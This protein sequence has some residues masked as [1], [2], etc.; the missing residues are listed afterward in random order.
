MNKLLVV[1]KSKDMIYDLI[2]L[3]DGFILSPREL[4]VN[5]PYFFF[6]DDILEIARRLKEKNKKVF[7]NINKN[8]NDDDLRRLKILLLKLSQ[9]AV[10]LIDG[11][12]YYD[13]SLVQLKIKYDLPFELIWAQEHMTNNYL[14]CNFW[15]SSGVN[16]V[17]L[18]NELMLEEILEIR[19]HTDMN[20][21]YQ[22][23]GYIP[24]FT[25]KRTLLTSYIDYCDLYRYSDRYHLYKEDHSYPILEDKDGTVLYTYFI[26]NA[27]EEYIKYQDQVFDYVIMNGIL[28]DDTIFTKI[29]SIFSR[30]DASCVKELSLE[31][32]QLCNDNTGK[33]FLYR[34]TVYKVKDYGKEEKA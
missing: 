7:L 25:S 20:L 19:K 21:F 6:Y 29:V 4:A 26:L 24:M 13:I 10:D 8:I 31:V 11:I 14:T 28:I 34:E 18:S 33:G 9:H 27:L 15:K 22:V 17:Q 3:V 23:F 16:G 2:D 32:D 30:A 12:F 5:A 1:P